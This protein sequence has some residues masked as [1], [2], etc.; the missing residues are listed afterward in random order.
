MGK[1]YLGS[2]M[3]RS[4]EKED[5]DDIEVKPLDEVDIALLKAYGQGQY[6]QSLKSVE[7]DISE[8]TKR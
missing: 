8:I 2:H 1:D 7:G 4:N 6:S 3:R 5:K